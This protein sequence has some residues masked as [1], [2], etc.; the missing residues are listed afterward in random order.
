MC[1]AN[2]THPDRT[3]VAADLFTYCT[4]E[5]TETWHVVRN[6]DARGIVDKVICKSCGSEHRYKKMDVKAS[7]TSRVVVRKPTGGSASPNSSGS[8]GLE[9]SW[10]AGIKKWGDKAPLEFNPE[11]SFGIGDV[12]NHTVFGK[13]VVQ[14]RRENKVDVLFSTGSK[15]LPSKAAR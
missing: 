6:H 3:P 8:K 9:E 15:T 1:P 7:S 4:R 13:G 10:Y 11:T 12:V 14:A 5:K 2:L